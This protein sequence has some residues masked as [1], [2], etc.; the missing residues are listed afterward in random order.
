MTPT[1]VAVLRNAKTL[2]IGLSLSITPTLG[3]QGTIR[4]EP[5]ELPAGISGIT[6]Q[7]GRLD[8]PA[9]RTPVPSGK[10]ELVFVRL[11]AT[12]R[13]TGSPIVYLAGGPGQSGAGAARND[14]SL[15]YL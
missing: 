9:I 14:F 1:A 10:I 4:W 12:K 6:A 13:G 5:Y 7:L 3:A 15:P 8:V 11:Q 2:A